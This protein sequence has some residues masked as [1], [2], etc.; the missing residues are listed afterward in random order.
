MMVSGSHRARERERKK[1]CIDTGRINLHLFTAI[2]CSSRS[3]KANTAKIFSPKMNKFN[4]SPSSRRQ[5]L[6][7]DRDSKARP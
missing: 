6:W 5:S 3:S 2:I 4:N 7:T 1:E